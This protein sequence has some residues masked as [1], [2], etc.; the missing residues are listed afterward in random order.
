MRE[1]ALP[2]PDDL[3]RALEDLA[4]AVVD[5]ASGAEGDVG[6]IAGRLREL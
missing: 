1:L 4:D 5:V 3:R 2:L 6:R